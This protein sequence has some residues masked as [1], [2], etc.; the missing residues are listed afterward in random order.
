MSLE[1]GMD[2]KKLKKDKSCSFCD[3]SAE[4]KED[5]ILH[6]SLEHSNMVTRFERNQNLPYD[7]GVEPASKEKNEK[8]NEDDGRRIV[9]RSNTGEIK[10]VSKSTYRDGKSVQNDENET[11]RNP[12]N[13]RPMR[14][15]SSRNRLLSYKEYLDDEIVED[16]EYVASED[17]DD[18]EVF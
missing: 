7:K 10:L 8:D 6:L 3:F 13:K 2:A 1:S 9:I 14:R 18:E 4:K 5:L 17:D 11:G 12:E 15:A 16:D